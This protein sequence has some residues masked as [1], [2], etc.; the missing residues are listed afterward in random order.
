M[1]LGVRVLAEDQAGRVLLVKHTYIKG[2][3]FPG[4]GVEHGETAESAALR[5]LAE[6]GG[7]AAT[8]PLTLFGVYSN[9]P[10]FPNDHVLFFQTGTVEASAVNPDPREIADYGFFPREALPD[11]VTEGTKLRL[12]EV[13]EG[14][15]LS[16]FWAPPR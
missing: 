11:G 8:E 13:F 14:R 5:E 16:P 9:A 10:A 6:E 1:T 12:A 7:V 2:W 3:H 4:G 15:A